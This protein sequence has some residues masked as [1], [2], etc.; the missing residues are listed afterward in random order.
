[1]NALIITRVPNPLRHL[2]GVVLLGSGMM[3]AT[4]ARGED[5]GHVG[6]ALIPA[7]TYEPQLRNK[8]E[9]E[10]VAVGAFWLDA[11]P[12][13]NAEFLEFVRTH[14]QW[15]RSRVSPL[16]ADRAYLADWAADLELGDRIPPDAPVVRV[17][18]FAARAFAKAHGKRLP[19]TAEWERAAAAGFSQAIG[20]TEP[21]FSAAILNWLAR[22]TP[23][24]LP[25][26]G[27]GRPNLFGAYDL[28]GLVWEWVDDFNTAMTTGESRA[29]TGLERNL[30]CGAGAAGARNLND[31]P[32]F[33]RA[34]LRSSIRANYAVPNLG[35]R[36]ARDLHLTTDSSL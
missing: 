17:S 1:M 32:G 2:F 16:F 4:L 7:G 36:G 20:A 5:A 28:H 9:P 21:G 25:N 27:Q 10:Q 15:R 19:T 26:V 23:A 33:M 12:V 13:T 22:P 3:G 35:F 30:F 24:P 31:Y 34:G 18:W 29:D 6:M 14:P 11:R 8:D